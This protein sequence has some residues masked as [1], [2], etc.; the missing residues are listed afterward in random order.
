MSVPPGFRPICYRTLSYIFE[1]KLDRQLGYAAVLPPL[2]LFC[3]SGW[4]QFTFSTSLRPS[5]LSYEDI[6]M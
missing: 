6:S 3:S 5:R 2:L 1:I 4:S